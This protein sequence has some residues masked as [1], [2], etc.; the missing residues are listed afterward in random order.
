M[1]LLAL[2]LL[3]FL[4]LPLKQAISAEGHDI[5][6]G[7]KQEWLNAARPLDKDDAQG[8][9]ILLDFWTY[10]CINCMQV[11]PDLKKLEAEFGDR[12]LVI[13]VHSAK[14]AGE[15]GSPRI[16]AAAKRFGITHPVINDSSFAVW[17]AFKV[18]A[19]PTQVLL[20]MQGSEAARYSGEGHYE[21]IRSDVARLLKGSPATAPAAP[22]AALQEREKAAGLLSF[23]ARLGAMTWA[24]YGEL[25]FAAD[26]GHNRIVAFGRDGAVRMIIGSGRQGREDGAF[27]AASFNQP[28]GFALVPGGIYVADTGNHLIRWVSLKSG[29]VYTVAGTGERGFDRGLAD[30]PALKAALASPWDVK[31]LKDKTTL[32]IANAG[33]HQLLAL[34]GRKNTVSVLAG[35]G[36]EDVIDG[37]AAKAA[38]A[39]PSALS[40]A[41]DAVY[42]ADAESSALRVLEKGA[43]KTLIGTGLFDFGHADG[44][45]PKAMLQHPQGLYA[46]EGRILVADTYN[47]AL[48]AYDTA[49]GA[50]STLKIGDA[51][52][53]PGDV[54][55]LDG[56]LYVADTNNHRIAVIDEATGK[57]SELALKTPQKR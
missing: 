45:Y 2:A 54:L 21:K 44:K 32:V 9:V 8:R 16:L 10:G 30:A 48:R 3:A 34:D 23:P 42:F 14:F 27:D 51:L 55:K 46:E 37:P 7:G 49:T 39:Q 36:R 1:R 15:K 12:L 17:Q 25:I 56:K 20:D 4:L 57:V 31:L 40:V 13:G 52:A 35:S 53:E 19:W 50:L 26:S 29:Q 24:G 38:L 43:V 6:F 28:R 22:L 47:N 18:N 33:T 5:L 41:G 11:V